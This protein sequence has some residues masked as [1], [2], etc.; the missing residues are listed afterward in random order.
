M[1]TD[2]GRFVASDQIPQEQLATEERRLQEVGDRVAEA[3]MAADQVAANENVSDEDRR[4][5]ADAVASAPAHTPD[6]EHRG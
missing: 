6:D 1:S 2:N 5:A 3:Q 4:A